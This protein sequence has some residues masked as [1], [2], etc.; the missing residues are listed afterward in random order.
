MELVTLNVRTRRVCK[1]KCN[2]TYIPVFSSGKK[3][4]HL[5]LI[6]HVYEPTWLFLEFPAE[7]GTHGVFLGG[8][9]GPNIWLFR[10]LMNWHSFLLINVVEAWSPQD[11]NPHPQA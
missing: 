7:I 3:N 9:E 5:G 1:S 6:D 10:V 8:R 2:T 11:L 4:S